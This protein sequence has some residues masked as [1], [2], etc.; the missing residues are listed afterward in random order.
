LSVTAARGRAPV[1]RAGAAASV[2]FMRRRF[3]YLR[4]F[5]GFQRRGKRRA[6]CRGM[7][8][9]VESLVSLGGAGSF[10]CR[11]RRWKLKCVMKSIL[12][13]GWLLERYGPAERLTAQVA[14]AESVKTSKQSQFDGLNPLSSGECRL[15]SVCY[16]FGKCHGYYG[17]L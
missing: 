5:Y 1:P 13:S 8:R 9:K 3:K 7:R 14:V 10:H 15:R 16:Q 2:M 11:S 17:Y 4:L 12:S 6:F